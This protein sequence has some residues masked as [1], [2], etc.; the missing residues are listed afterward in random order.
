MIRLLLA[1]ALLC[2]PSLAYLIALHPACLLAAG[3]W[4]LSTKPIYLRVLGT[5]GV[6]SLLTTAAPHFMWDGF[7]ELWPVVMAALV[8]ALPAAVC[9]LLVWI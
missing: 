4:L 6:A 2:A 8:G 9:S 1:A 7:R 3:D 5:A